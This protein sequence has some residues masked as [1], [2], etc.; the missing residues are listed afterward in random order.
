M[1]RSLISGWTIPWTSQFCHHRPSLA[2]GI[3]W[4]FSLHWANQWIEVEVS[5]NNAVYNTALL[6]RNE[7]KE[8]ERK[9]TEKDLVLART[10]A[11]NSPESCI[12]EGEM[13]GWSRAKTNTGLAQEDL[14]R[15]ARFP[16]FQIPSPMPSSA[17]LLHIPSA[18]NSWA[19]HS[20]EP[21]LKSNQSLHYLFI[22]LYTIWSQVWSLQLGL[23]HSKHAY[24]PE[25]SEQLSM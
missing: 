9:K 3:P 1:T 10:R 16:P 2:H 23:L 7:G 13:G 17:A 12:S 21:L 4:L 15:W 20:L 6:T 8:W 5:T 24:T 25:D 18:V 22:Y 19:C 14:H 11:V